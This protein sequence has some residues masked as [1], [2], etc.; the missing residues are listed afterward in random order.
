M[1][2]K[3][4]RVRKLATEVGR[5][6]EDVVAIL[7]TV[8]IRVSS[9]DD[10]VPKSKLGLARSRLGL[11]RREPDRRDIASLANRGGSTEIDVRKLLLEAGILK[12]LRHAKLASVP[13]LRH[14]EE[15]LGLRKAATQST[16]EVAAGE[17]GL[18]DLPRQEVE[19]PHRSAG[20]A[21]DNAKIPD[22]VIVGKVQDIQYLSPTD[23][24]I[25][26]YALV[27]DFKGSKDPIDPPGVR[28]RGLLESAASRPRTSL[29]KVDKY[30]TADMAG[31]ALTH[32]I[33]H[34]HAFHNGNKRTAL[35]ALLVFLDKNGFW[36]H[37]T[38]D[39]MYD[40]LLQIAAHSLCYSD[41]DN[42]VEGPDA[43]VEYI[44]IWL[45]YRLQGVKRSE[46]RR[47]W[48]QLKKILAHYDCT[49]EIVQGNRMNISRAPL[50]TQVAFRN[51]GTDVEIEVVRKV[52]KDLELDEEHGYDSD[53]FYNRDTKLPKFIN[54]YRKLL[55]RLAKM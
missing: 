21:E 10:Q 55:G 40:L 27:K 39:E 20:D 29:G 32:A 6:V 2:R 19:V 8:G 14:A 26:H 38:Q 45:S 51:W 7:R 23:I 12:K 22:R 11:E 30:P 13:L 44:A 46:R 18:E 33:V 35:V 41:E 36:L 49:L 48:R 5:S 43:E 28:S 31:A 9:G 50:R 16:A 24:E 34:N 42:D 4:I 17:V 25:I 53:I 47:Q 52:R 54:D 37:T 3:R 1:P 15:V